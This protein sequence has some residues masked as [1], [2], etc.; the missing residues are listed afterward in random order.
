MTDPATEKR[1]DKL[2]KIRPFLITLQ[3]NF[4]HLFAP[5]VA[6]S[7][8]EV[9]IKYNGRLRWKHYM[10]MKPIKRGGHQVVGVCSDFDCIIAMKA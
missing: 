10:P 9:M 5:G 6:L 8:D 2:G 7:V 4:P 3:H 1:A